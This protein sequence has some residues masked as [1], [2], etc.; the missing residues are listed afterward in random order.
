MIEF[1]VTNVEGETTWF[2]RD[3]GAGFAMVDAEN[4][5]LPF[6]HLRGAPDL[7]WHG[8]GLAMVARVV[9][10]HGGRIWTEAEPGVGRL[11]ISPCPP[12][13]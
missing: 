13:I 3:N 10:R 9:E 8:I 5:F 1:G 2:V 4:H 11:S 7:G 6:W 12:T